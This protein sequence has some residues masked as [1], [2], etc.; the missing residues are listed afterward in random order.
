MWPFQCPA[1]PASRCDGNPGLDKMWTH[2]GVPHD[3]H[4]PP[5]SV[6]GAVMRTRPALSLTDA[7]AA[8]VLIGCV[9]V[10][11]ALLQSI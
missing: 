5:S 9:A 3:P 4:I 10:V 11:I 7:V 8:V 6:P 1:C 2:R